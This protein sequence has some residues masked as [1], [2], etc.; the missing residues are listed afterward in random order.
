MTRRTLFLLGLLAPLALAGYYLL[1]NEQA[2]VVDAASSALDARELRKRLRPDAQP[3]S[4]PNEWQFRIA[5][6]PDGMVPLEGV[7]RAREQAAAIR[8]RGHAGSRAIWQQAGPLNIGGRVTDIALNPEDPDRVFV[9]SAA[10]GVFRTVN[11]GADWQPVF[12]EQGALA[13][14]DIVLDPQNPQRIWVGTG[15]SNSSSYGFPG[16][17]LWTS[18]DGGDTWQP[19]GLDSS[20]YVG[21]ILVDPTDSQRIWVAAMGRLYG[22]GGQRG[23]YRS[24]D[25]G[26]SWTRTLFVNDSTSAVDLALDP[27]DPDRVY[28][29]TWQRL[30]TL[31]TRISGGPGTR[32]WRSDDGGVTWQTLDNGLPAAGMLGRPAIAVAPTDAQRVYVSFADDPGYFM[33]LWRSTNGGDSFTQTSDG[34][35]SNLYSS[36][37]WYFG[38]LRVD[39]FD[40]DHVLALGVTWWRSLNGGT[41]Y[42]R[43]AYGLHVD[44]HA[45]E[46]HPLTG[47]WWIGNDGG[48]YSS[49]NLIDYLHYQNL[50]LS[51]FYTIEIDP[52]NPQALYGGTQDNGTVRTLSGQ[53][54]DW[55]GILGGD[56]FHVVVHPQVPG[57]VFAEYQWG[58]LHRS[59]DGGET[60][61]PSTTG[62]PGSDRRNWSTP[63][64]LDPVDTDNLYYGTQR[65]WRSTDLGLTWSAISGDLTGGFSGD[66][67]F[68]TLT[69]ISVSPLDN[70]VLWV[71]SD[72]GRVARSLNGGGSW[73]QVGTA[74]PDRWITDLV[75]DPHHAQGALVSLGGLRWN[76]SQPHIFRTWDGGAHWTAIDGGLP[77]AP[78]YA[79]VIDPADSL[80]IWAGCETGCYTTVDGGQTWT[81]A[82]PGLPLGPVLDLDF[83]APTRMLAAGTH[84]RSAFRLFVDD[85]SE[86]IPHVRIRRVGPGIELAWSPVAGALDYRIHSSSSPFPTEGQSEVLATVAD[87]LFPHSVLHLDAR[88]FYRVTARFP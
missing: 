68:N 83:H 33:G 26:A 56:G 79:L 69:C 34:A 63:V 61:V 15:E 86:T 88:R 5:A 32:I 70:Q 50:P 73:Q 22:T 31:T 10:G 77:H 51:Q 4:L 84:G 18:G 80:R 81:E 62:I 52:N 78:V 36:F 2:R 20:C 85:H 72:D 46:R 45:L 25:G 38:N 60:F 42:N 29:A 59:T 8:A 9:A 6:W 43:L 55:D 65:L 71:G 67:G 3:N 48:L 49:D 39:P 21:R 19:S 16:N 7:F 1:A 75:A 24:T 87:T 35:L 74:L 47:R 40:E 28:A 54:G 41:S 66:A 64:V 27:A 76:E 44:F 12:Q 58:S 82:A 17:G 23:V 14:G 30:R 11:G 57:L 13:I 53:E 37:G